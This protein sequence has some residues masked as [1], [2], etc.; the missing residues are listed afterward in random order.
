LLTSKPAAPLAI[1]YSNAAAGMAPI[2][3][4]HMGRDLAGG[5][6]AAGSKADG[7]GGVKMTAGD[8]TYG[9]G[10]RQADNG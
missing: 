4:D 10:H 2:T 7:H 5:E 9:I 1:A 8:V 6:T 3:C